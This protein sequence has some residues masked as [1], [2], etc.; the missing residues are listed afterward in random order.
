MEHDMHAMMMSMDKKLDAM[1]KHLGCK[2]ISEEEYL[3]KSD[4]EKDAYDAENMKKHPAEKMER[5]G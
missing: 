1:M 2:Q 5:M 3:S 4:E